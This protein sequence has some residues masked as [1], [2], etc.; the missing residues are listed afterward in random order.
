MMRFY[1][2]IGKIP[3]K[4]GS[5]Y[6]YAVTRFFEGL[7]LACVQCVDAGLGDTKQVDYVASKALGLTVGPFTATT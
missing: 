7:L 4:V 2:R 1:E 3:I 6:G 5:R